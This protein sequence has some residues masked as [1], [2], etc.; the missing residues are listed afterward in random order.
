[1]GGEGG[2]VAGVAY[3]ITGQKQTQ[4]N[5]VCI[6]F[7]SLVNLYPKVLTSQNLCHCTGGVPCCGP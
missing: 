5:R 1:M 3:F 4:L 2:G 6:F 7:I